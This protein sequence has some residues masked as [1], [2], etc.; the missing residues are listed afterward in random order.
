MAHALVDA[1]R[2]VRA[3][4]L[5]GGEVLPGG[6][7][8]AVDVTGGRLLAFGSGEKGEPHPFGAIHASARYL[9][10]CGLALAELGAD[11]DA[12]AFGLSW[13]RHDTGIP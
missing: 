4:A 2:R 10:G 6:L 11:R 5:H 13:S 3:V 1:G 12:L 9:N 7:G 8:L